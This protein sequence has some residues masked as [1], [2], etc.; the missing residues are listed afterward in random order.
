M[1]TLQNSV[2]FNS[3]IQSQ[4]FELSAFPDRV[5]RLYFTDLLGAGIGIVLCFALMGNMTLAYLDLIPLF[6]GLA[7]LL[8]WK[9][10]Q[11]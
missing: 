2:E 10:E 1:E 4:P 9:L 5:A 8:I 7:L 11:D 6:I 3:T